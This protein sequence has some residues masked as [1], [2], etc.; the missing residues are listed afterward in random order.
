LFSERKDVRD[1]VETA[2]EAP[3]SRRWSRLALHQD[4]RHVVFLSSAPGESP[5]RL[6]Q[7]AREFGRGFPM[8]VPD[9]GLDALLP[10]V[11]ALSAPRRKAI[12]SIAC[13]CVTESAGAIPWPVASART[14]SSP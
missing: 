11:L 1:R 5:H 4:Y 7:D 10:E 3:V 14:A 2:P 8:V 13:I 12:R 6:E 9:Y